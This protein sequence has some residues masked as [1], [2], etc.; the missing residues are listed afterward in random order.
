MKNDNKALTRLSRRWSSASHWS[1]LAGGQAVCCAPH[2]VTP[3]AAPEPSEVQATRGGGGAYIYNERETGPGGGNKKKTKWQNNKR[4]YNYTHRCTC[5]H[6]GP[7]GHWTHTHSRPPLIT[8]RDM[9]SE[10]GA[11][12]T[13]T[14][15]KTLVNMCTN[16]GRWSKTTNSCT[17]VF[18]SWKPHVLH[19]YC[20]AWS[21]AGPQKPLSSLFVSCFLDIL[22]LLNLLRSLHQ[23]RTVWSGFCIIA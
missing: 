19:V 21:A 13:L 1:R 11:C 6:R 23:S 17:G 12:C 16:T 14:C 15:K 4:G 22:L 3:S 20:D 9:A 8:K 2:G 18:G 5:G 7:H 10:T